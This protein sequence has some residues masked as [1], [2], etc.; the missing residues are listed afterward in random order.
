[1]TA[2]TAGGFTIGERV[3]LARLRRENMRL[4]DAAER[5]LMS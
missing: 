4:S 5:A 2:T 1:L 3:E